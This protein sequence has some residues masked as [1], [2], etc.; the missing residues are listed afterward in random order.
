M[1]MVPGIW[2]RLTKRLG[3]I[4]VALPTRDIVL[5]AA[6]NDAAAM[7]G[8]AHIRTQVHENYPYQLSENIFAWDNGTWTVLG[9]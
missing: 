7:Q 6:R 9:E 4:A 5:V 1:M 8:L 2:N 3:P